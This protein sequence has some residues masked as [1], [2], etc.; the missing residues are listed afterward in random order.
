MTTPPT[1]YLAVDAEQA[2]ANI[3]RAAERARAAGIAYRPHVKTHKTIE[4]ARMQAQAGANGLTV[5]TIG[6]AEV[7]AD[8][9]FD[10]L[11]IAYPLWIDDLARARVRAL[12]ERGVRV[13]VGTDAAEAARRLAGTGARAV[14][15][16]DSGHGRSGALPTDAGVVARAASDAGVEVAGV[17]TFPGHAYGLA[18][19][20]GAADDEA[21]ALTGAIDALRAAGVPEPSRGFVRSGGSTPSAPHVTSAL[22][23]LRPG[24]NA[25]YDAGQWELGIATPE[26][27]ALWAVATV[28]SARGTRIVVDAGSKTLGADRPG[29]ASGFGRLLDHPDARIVQLSEHH[30][31]VELPEGAPVPPLGTRVRVAPNHV[32]S[33]VNLHDTLQIVGAD[34]IGDGPADRP[35]I[36]TWLVTAR[37]KNA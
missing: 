14:I 9:G 13:L 28:V 7:F 10:D 8:A 37:G 12:T 5:A 29:Y 22:T 34:A 6:E 31:V 1:P 17:F 23:E 33:A 27:I 24:V 26:Q 15:E 16:I 20:Q 19:G 4:L 36:G 30:A 25:L 21:A 18:A 11:F 3:E 32:C 35:V 2:Q